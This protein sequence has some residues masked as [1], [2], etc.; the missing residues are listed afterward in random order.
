VPAKA[1]LPGAVDCV[2][3]GS[4]RPSTI[5][6]TCADNGIGVQNMTWTTWTTSAATGQ[7]MLWLNL[8]QPN[9]ADGK[10]AYYPVQVR[11]SNVQESAHGQWFRDLTITWES[12]RPSPV[13]V[14]TYSLMTPN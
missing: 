12:P 9:C 6:L 13:P 2:G 7:G 5:T 8:C 1:A 14:S 11:L 3:P 10:F 4:V